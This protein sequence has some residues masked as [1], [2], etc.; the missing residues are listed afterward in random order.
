M[1][2]VIADDFTGAAEIGG[3]ALRHGMSVVIGTD[4]KNIG[5]C[6]LF[7]ITADTRS[8]SPAD[9]ASEVR[10]ITRDL[11]ALK[12]SFIFKKLDSV[13]RGNIVTELEAQLKEM[14]LSKAIVVAGNPIFGR[15][16]EKG[17]YTVKGIPL[18]ES[19]FAD[20]PEYPIST[21]VVTE[22]VG[23]STF[24]VLSC[25]IGDKMPDSGLVFGDV[26]SM[27]DMKEWVEM[28]DDKCIAAGGS[29][30]FGVILDKLYGVASETKSFAYKS[31]SKSLF[32]FGSMYPKSRNMLK[33]MDGNGLKVMNMPE[34]IYRET[35]I[36]KAAVSAWA[37]DIADAVNA[38]HRVVVTA[39]HD[40]CR[41]DG[42]SLNIKEIMGFLVSE[43]LRLQNDVDSL[44][45]EGGAT[46]SAILKRMGV[47]IL[48]PTCELE[49]GIIQMKVDGFPNL[50]VTTK[51]GSYAWPDVIWEN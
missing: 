21:S 26:T 13:L 30:F 14:N 4:V 2:A 35:E 44:L 27:N 8:M 47:K 33:R 40:D 32:I 6:D 48:V 15:L 38:S 7:I 46:T 36:D 10:R 45:I 24:G 5:D 42:V 9:A 25:S 28:L 12:P 34:S 16:I 18:A 39:Y 20:D 11:I 49:L 23:E 29:G 37:A 22:I 51:P 3:V 43:V 1:L 41:C 50:N 19:F 31:G 17:L